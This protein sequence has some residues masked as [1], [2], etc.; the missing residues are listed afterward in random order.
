MLKHFAS[1][2]KAAPKDVQESV[3]TMLGKKVVLSVA[4]KWIDLSANTVTPFEFKDVKV[5]KPSSPLSIHS[6]D[7]P[8][9]IVGSY[10]ILSK[11]LNI[12]NEQV[13]FLKTT[14]KTLSKDQIASELIENIN[15]KNEKRNFLDLSR[16]TLKSLKHVDC[17]YFTFKFINSNLHFINHILQ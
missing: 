16:F 15:Y 5:D 10:Q 3:I 8:K 13:E 1:E 9:Y 7:A 12:L 2:L 14:Y 6:S 17:T 11:Y 4:N